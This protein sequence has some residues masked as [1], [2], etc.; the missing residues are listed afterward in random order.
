MEISLLA[1]KRMLE[2]VY[3][4]RAI[5]KVGLD[6]F[7]REYLAHNPIANVD[8]DDIKVHF[9]CMKKDENVWQLDAEAHA[10]I[11]FGAWA[12]ELDQNAPEL[13]MQCGWFISMARI[14]SSIQ[15]QN[16][17]L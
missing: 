17:S 14:G 10:Y 1:E 3:E 15:Y 9:L 16:Y 2:Y 5:Q 13:G 6:S 8:V 4:Q 12:A 11:R 7:W